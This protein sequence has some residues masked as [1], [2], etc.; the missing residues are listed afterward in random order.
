MGLKWK[1]VIK[2]FDSYGI[3]IY[4]LLTNGKKKKIINTKCCK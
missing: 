3:I 2:T 4:D 1:R